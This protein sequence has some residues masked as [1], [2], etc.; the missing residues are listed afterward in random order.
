MTKTASRPAT[1]EDVLAAPEHLVAEILD[2]RL[3]AHPRPAR[4]HAY[5]ASV[6][7]GILT[8]PFH[9]EIGGPG[10]WYILDEPELHFGEKP[11]EEITVPELAG[12]RIEREPGPSETIS[13]VTVPDWTCEIVSPS[14]ERDDRVIKRDIYAKFGVGYY[15]I[16]DPRKRA[17]ETFVRRN[18]VLEPAETYRDGDIAAASPFSEVPFSLDRLWKD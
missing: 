9:E 5:A 4:K 11:N 15:W 18:G 1:Y 7:G 17:L 16:C 6:L 12:W 14:S 8:P 10:G 2:G 13:F 3:V